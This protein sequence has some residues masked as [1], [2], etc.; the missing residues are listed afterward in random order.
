M[1]KD[2]WMLWGMICCQISS[3][4]CK[5]NDQLDVQFGNWQMGSVVLSKVVAAMILHTVQAQRSCIRP[6]CEIGVPTKSAVGR[7]TN[8]EVLLE[9]VAPHLLFRVGHISKWT[10]SQL[11]R[12]F[13][14]PHQHQHQQIQTSP[15]WR[16]SLLR[17]RPSLVGWRPSLLGTYATYYFYVLCS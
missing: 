15:C 11:G 13:H 7:I 10:S 8:D 9:L 5:F 17:W 12:C 1:L 2:R 16:L 6:K 14:R 4:N 3:A